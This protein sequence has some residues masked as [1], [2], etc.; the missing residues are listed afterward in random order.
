VVIAAGMVR[1]GAFFSRSAWARASPS[2]R[3]WILRSWRCPG[4]LTGSS[5]TRAIEVL[6]CPDSSL[7]FYRLSEPRGHTLIVK[8]EHGVIVHAALA[9]EEEGAQPITND[10]G[11]PVMVRGQGGNVLATSAVALA[12]ELVGASYDEAHAR[13]GAPQQQALAYA[14]DS[15]GAASLVLWVRDGLVVSQEVARD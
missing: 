7:S 6:G 2:E 14:L 9:R 13:L 10:L 4:R 3:A 5:G 12:D 11:K 1:G 8:H 15:V